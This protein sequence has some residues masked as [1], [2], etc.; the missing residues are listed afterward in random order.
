MIIKGLQKTTLLDYPGCVAATIFTGGC[1]YRC[2]FCHNMNLVNGE[3]PNTISEEEVLTFLS[4]R[5]GVLDGV[6]ITGGEPTLQRDLVSFIG[7]IRKMGYKVKLDTNGTNSNV[8]KEL[9]E[10]NMLDYVAMDIKASKEKYSLCCGVT[11]TG[12]DEIITSVDII[13][14]SGIDYEFRTTLVKELHDKDCFIGG[15]E[16]IKGA[17]K[18]YLQSFVD[19][20]YVPNHN[21]SAFD[22]KT[23]QQYV[24]IAARYVECAQIRGV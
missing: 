12:T 11:D 19:S 3:E 16:I 4:K 18:Y 8:I 2:P 22:E 23:L 21:F 9:F 6:C 24:E 7:R 17:K 14:N 15:C 13:M 20:E 1:N 5:K 10:K